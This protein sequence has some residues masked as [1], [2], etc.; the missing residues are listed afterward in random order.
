MKRFARWS[1][2]TAPALAVLAAL[3]ARVDIAT[4]PL[5]ARLQ[6][7]REVRSAGLAW[8]DAWRVAGMPAIAGGASLTEGQHAGEFLLGERSADTRET[9]TVLSGQNLKAGAVVGR[10]NKGVGRVST[11]TVVGTGNG[12]ATLVF[13]GP[14]VELGNYVLTCITAVANG[15]VFSLV[16]PSGK[17]LPNLTLTVGAGATTAYTSRHINFSI[18]DGSTDFAVNDAFTF[19]VSTTAPIVIGTGNGTISGLSLGPDAKTGTYR[20]EN[21]AAVVNG[22]EFKVISPDGDMIANGFIVAGA[23][24]TWVLANQRQLNLTVTDG[25]TDFAV[26]DAFNVCVFNQ[27]PALAPGKVV[28]WDPTTFDGRDDVAGILYDNVDA[29]AADKTGVIVSRFAEVMKGSLIWGA[30]I[31]ASQKESAYL[32]L[33]KRGV[34]A[35]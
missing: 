23:G 27:A 6:R 24:G 2:S 29:S 33:A 8:L 12:T 4:K 7:V 31:T 30:A 18:T 22:G 16:A 34:I 17:A 10:V 32:D 19:I 14:E 15:G 9:V 20:V 5:W 21:I 13:A 26:A 3:L 11:P 28:A 1:D 35:L 25:A